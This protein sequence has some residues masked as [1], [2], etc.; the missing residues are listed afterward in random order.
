[1]TGTT[2]PGGGL[3]EIS[4]EV[5]D[6]ELLRYA[7][8]FRALTSGNGRFTRSYLRHEQVPPGAAGGATKP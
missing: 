4:A 8:E 2:T 3:T 7:I 5:R 6:Q 1:M